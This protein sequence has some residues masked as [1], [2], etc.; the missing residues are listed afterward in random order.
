AGFTTNDLTGKD[1]DSRSATFGK[2]QIFWKPN[3]RWEA[4]ALF[5]GERARDGDYA[6]S[7]LAGLRAR[8]FHAFRNVE[9]FTHRNIQSQTV[10]VDYLGSKV[11][12][13]TTTRFLHW[14]THDLTDLDYTSLALLT[15]SDD[16]KDFQFT[17]EA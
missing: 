9:G 14:D 6:L 12:F 2:G 13:S 4:R 5:N 16:E 10:Q 11:D 3:A 1:I 15:R 7:D 8:P 17:E